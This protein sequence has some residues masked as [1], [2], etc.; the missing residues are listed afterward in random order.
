MAVNLVGSICA[1]FYKNLKQL[2]DHLETDPKRLKMG[3]VC[4]Y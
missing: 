2:P 4:N 1:R 3:G